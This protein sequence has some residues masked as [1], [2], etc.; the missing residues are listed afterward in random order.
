MHTS[1]VVLRPIPLADWGNPPL[2]RGA[3]CTRAAYRSFAIIPSLWDCASCRFCNFRLLNTKFGLRTAS[4]RGAVRNPSFRFSR[5]KLQTGQRARYREVYTTQSYSTAVQSHVASDGYCRD[6][7]IEPKI[8]NSCELW[9][10]KR[11]LIEP[12][13]VISLHHGELSNTTE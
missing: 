9:V 5:R 12:N 8:T 11:P 6:I 4:R 3:G 7:E 1:V 2:E 13:C 10:R